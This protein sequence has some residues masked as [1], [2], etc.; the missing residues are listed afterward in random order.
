MRR[1]WESSSG[2]GERR[3]DGNDWPERASEAWPSCV[4]VQVLDAGRGTKHA[5]A[6][7]KKAKL[8]AVSPLSNL[9]IMPMLVISPR[10]LPSMRHMP[11]RQTTILAF[12]S[13]KIPIAPS[14]CTPGAKRQP[15]GPAND[16]GLHR[17]TM[18]NVG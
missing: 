7:T 4:Q 6:A 16:L 11:T 1:A 13:A 9:G 12:P 10:G 18:W 17:P 15:S 5:F 8:Q 14:T 2:K 3:D